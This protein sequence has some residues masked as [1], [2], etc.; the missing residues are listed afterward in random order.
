MYGLVFLRAE[1]E[2]V[3]KLNEIKSC[4]TGF[5]PGFN[6]SASVNIVNICPKLRKL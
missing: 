5:K 1:E 4:L 3:P 6:Y 2:P